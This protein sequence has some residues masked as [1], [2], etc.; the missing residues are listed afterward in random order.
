[1]NDNTETLN[2]NF[3]EQLNMLN[4]LEGF[5]GEEYSDTSSYHSEDYK[6]EKVIIKESV[7]SISSLDRDWINGNLESP[8]NFNVKLQSGLQNNYMMIDL[9]PKNI[10]YIGLDSVILNGRD[11][12]ISYTSNT[13][14]DITHNPYLIVSAENIDYVSYGTNKQF[15]NALG[16]II[17][18]TVISQITSDSPYLEYKNILTKGKEYQTSP[19]ASL[20]KLNLSITTPIGNHPNKLYDVLN[21]NNITHNPAV[22]SNTASEYLVIKTLDYFPSSQYKLGDKL[23]IKNYNQE[24]SGSIFIDKFESFINRDEGHTIIGIDTTDN[25]KL[26]K[27]RIHIPAPI[28]LSTTTGDAVDS[29]WYKNIKDMSNLRTTSDINSFNENSGRLINTNLQTTLLIKVKSVD[30]ELK[31]N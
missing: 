30:K 28:E 4:Q 17:P 10:I 29:D 24:N 9:E 7:L 14:I 21:I 27:N 31:M 1:M 13:N 25:T 12:N 5:D 22:L 16:V 15:N 8:Y 23:L 20:S 2:Q 11:H 19:L 26:L 3:L 6:F 18:F